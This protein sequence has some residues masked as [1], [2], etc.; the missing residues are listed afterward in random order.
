M[1]VINADENVLDI[2]GGKD[3]QFDHLL[4]DLERRTSPN[5]VADT[6]GVQ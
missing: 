3:K 2:M 4:Q 1:G 5:K 6:Q